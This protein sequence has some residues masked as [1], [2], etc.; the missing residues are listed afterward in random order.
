MFEPVDH[1]PAP[2]VGGLPPNRVQDAIDAYVGGA[3]LATI[4]AELCI[5]QPWPGP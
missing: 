2:G 4:V 5:R 1:R 3:S